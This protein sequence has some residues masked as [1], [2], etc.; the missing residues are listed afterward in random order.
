[1]LENDKEV[2]VQWDDLYFVVK[3]LCLEIPWSGNE[4]QNLAFH[5]NLS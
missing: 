5:V 3:P 2:N 1:M 4:D